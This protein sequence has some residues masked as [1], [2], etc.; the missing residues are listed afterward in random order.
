MPAPAP[1]PREGGRVG[2]FG[3]SCGYLHLVAVYE[4]PGDRFD[5]YEM[6]SDC[7]EWFLKYRVDAKQVFAALPEMRSDWDDFYAFS[8]FC[9]VR[10]KTGQESQDDD[11]F[12][13]LQTPGKAIRLNLVDG[14]SDK[15]C[16]LEDSQEEHGSLAYLEHAFQYV[17]S[18]CCV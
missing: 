5:V 7:D 18:L 16:D 6:K 4:P 10:G 15:I 9:L 2:Y 3:E 12:L 13:V 17:E 11:S 1:P 14:S 8:I